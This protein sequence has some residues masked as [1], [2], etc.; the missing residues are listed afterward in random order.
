V[1]V[2]VPHALL[3]KVRRPLVV[4][5]EEGQQL[6]ARLFNPAVA[7][8]ARPG[9]RLADEADARVAVF[10][11]EA[12]PF[13]RRAVVHDHDLEVAE[14]LRRGRIQ[15]APDVRLLVVE[16]DDD[17]DA[18]RS[19]TVEGRGADAL[20]GRGARRELAVDFNE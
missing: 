20:A 1:L 3:E 4:C 18:H 10:F 6:A 8:G 17:G 13:V 9:V 19:L 11:D 5:V 16:R 7:R 14:G 2:Q 15:G 12:R